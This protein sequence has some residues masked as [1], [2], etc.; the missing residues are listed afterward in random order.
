MSFLKCMDLSNMFFFLLFDQSQLF[1]CELEILTLHIQLHSLHIS[2]DRVSPEVLAIFFF[3]YYCARRVG[4]SQV[5]C[6]GGDA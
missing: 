3:L 4:A 2:L 5:S 1:Y 6:V